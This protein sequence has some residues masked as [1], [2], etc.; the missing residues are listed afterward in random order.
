[1]SLLPELEDIARTLGLDR[2][3]VQAG[4]VGGRSEE[5]RARVL[6]RDAAAKQQ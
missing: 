3:R 4:L 6:E 1:M 2:A 5:L